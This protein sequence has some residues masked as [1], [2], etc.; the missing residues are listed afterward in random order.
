MCHTIRYH[1]AEHHNINLT[2]TIIPNY[3]VPNSH[4]T[5]HLSPTHQSY[6]TQITNQSVASPFSCTFTIYHNSYRS[7][8]HNL[9]C[10]RRMSFRSV[11]QLL[12]CD[13]YFLPASLPFSTPTR[14]RR[15]FLSTRHIALFSFS[16]HINSLETYF[17]FNKYLNLSHSFSACPLL[18]SH[19][20]QLSLTAFFSCRLT[21]CTLDSSF[22][23]LYLYSSHSFIFSVPNVT[24]SNISTLFPVTSYILSL[25]SEK[26]QSVH[27]A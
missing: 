4:T 11:T 16:R 24:R 10:R 3:K 18:S 6:I 13:N 25:F 8:S 12:C 9:I 2:T 5:K 17:F 21:F 19:L 7:L 27:L 20:L 15:Q 22:L 14:S 1:N 26:T 23:Y